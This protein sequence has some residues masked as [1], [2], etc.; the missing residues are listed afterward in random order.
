MEFVFNFDFIV[1]TFVWKIAYFYNNKCKINF[2]ALGKSTSIFALINCTNDDK[3][4]STI[5]DFFF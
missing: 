4:V 2:N 5:V 3:G 1:D